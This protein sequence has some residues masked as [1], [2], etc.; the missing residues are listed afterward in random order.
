MA[1]RL[2]EEGKRVCVLERGRKYPPGSFARTPQ[3]LRSNFW[4]PARGTY[5]LF[6][7]WS[8]RHIA[9]IVAAG[10]G[11]GSLI[12]AN[13]LIRKD[14]RWF[15]TDGL[16]CK[17]QPWPVTRKE[18]DPYY[19]AVEKVLKP[20]IFPDRYVPNS[21][22]QFMRE[23][24]VRMGISETNYDEGDPAKPQWYRPQLAVT[25][26]NR[27]SE[28][29]PGVVIDDGEWNLHNKPRETCRLCGECDVGC[30]FGSKNTLDYTYLSKA[31]LTG[32]AALYDLCEVESIQIERRNGHTAYRIGFVQHYPLMQ[33]K[34]EC[35]YV[36]AE[37]LVVACGTMGSTLLLLRNRRNLPGL[38]RNK[39]L[40]SRFSGN[41][42]YLAFA[43]F[44]KRRNPR[45]RREFVDL[46]ASRSPVITSTFRFPDAHDTANGVRGHYVQDAGYPVIADYV[47]ELLSPVRLFRRAARFAGK[48][49]L[50][51][52]TGGGATEIGGQ[53]R[54]LVGDARGSSSS[55][56]LLGM[57]R[58]TPNGRMRLNLRRR[59]T[60]SWKSTRS[61]PYFSHVDASA[62]RIAKN[63]GG[64][65]AQNP[66]TSLFN[67]LITVHPLGGC[68]M[69]R[70]AQDGV[71]DQF[72]RVFGCPGLW[73]AD[74]S[75]MPG[76]VGA[77]PSMTIAA[78]AERFADR[79][80]SQWNLQNWPDT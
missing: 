56:P 23:A 14:E 58:D 13:V 9:A 48:L 72:G 71:V 1:L 4:R 35:R 17:A 15:F 43:R 51:W 3:E 76:P 22:T 74:G 21:K 70:S 45:G 19:D 40:G 60:V 27:C 34:S 73:V 18:L 62:K 61:Q 66:V 80:V 54:A 11:G 30:N 38:S 2:A 68:P 10:V 69:G 50:K 46:R 20:Q 59:L 16:A 25:F 31:L 64:V 24:A 39:N 5:G 41:G 52:F 6:D 28:P 44:V 67:T 49:L 36:Y 57:G 26:A 75:V 7:V 29:Q 55:M 8:F 37:R 65:Y 47:W 77:N 63:L 53:L 42:D 79:M 32:N 12:Y 33:R 78:L